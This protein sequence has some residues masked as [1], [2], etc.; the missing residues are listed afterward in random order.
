MNA[1]KKKR[2]MR[3]TFRG[4]KDVEINEFLKSEP[5]GHE[6]A[7]ELEGRPRGWD[8]PQSSTG[9]LGQSCGIRIPNNSV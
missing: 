4:A 5:T 6:T 2:E 8:S 1:V 7:V 3:H 9:H